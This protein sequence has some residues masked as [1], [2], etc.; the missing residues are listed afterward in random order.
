MTY[1][2]NLKYDNFVGDMD[3]HFSKAKVINFD[4]IHHQC[5]GNKLEKP[6]QYYQTIHDKDFVNYENHVRNETIL[7][8]IKS[9]GDDIHFEHG[10]L[11]QHIKTDVEKDLMSNGFFIK[12][13]NNKKT[14][15]DCK[16]MKF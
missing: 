3:S 14:P 16:K 5:R 4:I 2:D 7:T 6:E 1:I 8:A 10:F 15:D 9:E 13:N 11:K 12:K